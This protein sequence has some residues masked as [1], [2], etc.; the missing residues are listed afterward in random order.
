MSL[1]DPHPQRKIAKRFFSL[2]KPSGS[3][4]SRRVKCWRY[5]NDDLRSLYFEFEKYAE[6]GEMN[7]DDFER[8]VVEKTAH[9]QSAVEAIVVPQNSHDPFP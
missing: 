9:F 4:E 7:V 8:M 3:I 2:W 6:G 5:S 1:R